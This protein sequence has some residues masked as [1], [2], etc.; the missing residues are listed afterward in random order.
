[1]SRPMVIIPSRCPP[2]ST[3]ADTKD[4]PSKDQRTTTRTKFPEMFP[5]PKQS[6]RISKTVIEDSE[7]DDSAEEEIVTAG[8]RATLNHS[9]PRRTT[10]AARPNVVYETHR[11]PGE[12]SGEEEPSESESVSKESEA[13]IAQPQD[14]KPRHVGFPPV[15][16]LPEWFPENIKQMY[17][18]D[19]HG[20]ALSYQVSVLRL[21]TTTSNRF[22]ELDEITRYRAA[23]EII[24][25]RKWREYIKAG[26][27][28][29]QLQ[30]ALHHLKCRPLTKPFYK[31]RKEQFR[32]WKAKA[33]KLWKRLEKTHRGI[34]ILQETININFRQERMIHEKHL[35]GLHL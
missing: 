15:E 3:T 7:D 9:P 34:L 25:R 8:A 4:M 30:Q 29:W 22:Q 13:P 17:R 28:R 23:L 33:L 18:V 6:S 1:M 5:N 27:A 35:R 12:V 11:M 20:G 31:Y 32:T 21:P 10:L 16:E 2:K 14:T 26:K 24:Y 19:R